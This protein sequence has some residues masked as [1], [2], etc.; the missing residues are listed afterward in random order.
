MATHYEGTDEQRM[1]LD[2]YI[3][4]S[5]ASDV[6]NARINHHLH[7]VNLTGSQFGVL[8]ALYHLGPMPVG[9]LGDKILKSS[10]NMTLVVDNLVKRGLVSRNRRHDD[11]RRIDI[12]LTDDGRDLVAAI[13]PAH[14]EGVVEAFA[15]LS[16]EEMQQLGN[17][18]RRLGLA[19]VERKT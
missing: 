5:R 16:P 9:Q 10:G 15:V 6:L 14:V 2:A 13:M 19:Q 11:R 7:D 3:K 4:I 8:E 18:C 12:S 17:L 1:A